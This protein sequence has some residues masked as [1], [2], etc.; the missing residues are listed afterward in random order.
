M[1]S[2]EIIIVLTERKIVSDREGRAV[3]VG[4]KG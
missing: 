1:I 2:G 3:S 4:M